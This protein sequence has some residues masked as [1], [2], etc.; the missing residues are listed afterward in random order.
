MRLAN[1][2]R[3]ACGFYV[4]FLFRKIDDYGVFRTWVDEAVIQYSP[5]Y[6][7]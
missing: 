1:A 3:G 2:A 4:A 6:G 5:Y 7:V